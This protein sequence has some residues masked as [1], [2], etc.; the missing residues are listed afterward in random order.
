M[1]PKNRKTVP[2]LLLSLLVPMLSSG[3]WIGRPHVLPPVTFRHTLS[4]FLLTKKKIHIDL[5]IAHCLNIK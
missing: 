2:R 1:S 3:F 4:Y 5:T